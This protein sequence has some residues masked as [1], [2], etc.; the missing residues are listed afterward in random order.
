MRS[1]ASQGP[2]RTL[3]DLPRSALAP[4]ESIALNPREDLRVNRS[5]RGRKRIVTTVTSLFT[6]RH[7]SHD[8]TINGDVLSLRASQFAQCSR[9]NR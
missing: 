7:R 2:A 5:D 9:I 6:R 1:R 8:A 4:G 3:V